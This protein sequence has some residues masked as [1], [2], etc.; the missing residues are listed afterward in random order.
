MHLL[1][2]ID[3]STL[4]AHMAPKRANGADG[5]VNHT[6][7]PSGSK[8]GHGKVY[9]LAR[10]GGG[11]IL[12]SFPC[13]LRSCLVPLNASWRCYISGQS[14]AQAKHP[15]PPLAKSGPVPHKDLW[16]EVVRITEQLGDHV[17]WLHTPSHID[18]SSNSRAD[19]LAEVGRR[20]S[21]LLFGLISA[22]PRRHQEEEEPEEELVAKW[23]GWVP[24]ELEPS[25][26]P[27][28]APL[29]HTP[30]RPMI[31]QHRDA[32][33]EHRPPLSPLW[34]IKV[35]APV[36]ISQKTMDAHTHTYFPPS[37]PETRRGDG[38]TPPLS[39]R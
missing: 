6:M 28:P 3:L 37:D 12:D 31:G 18:T 16:E 17:K 24:E 8:L 15:L 25:A 38:N 11:G 33:P 13:P 20:K 23:E 32:T 19:Q 7:L 5:D 22:R 14:E 21:P 9:L 35:C 29:L 34:D 1:Y 10:G 2:G 27:R 39:P 26:L 36:Q 30:Q 4:L